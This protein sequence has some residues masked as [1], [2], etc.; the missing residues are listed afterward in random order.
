[1]NRKL[2]RK[3]NRKSEQETEQ[4]NEKESCTGNMKRKTEIKGCLFFCRIL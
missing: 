1:M 4:E 2:N 3:L